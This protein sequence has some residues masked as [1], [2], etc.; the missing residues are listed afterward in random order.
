M[1][2]ILV[3]FDPVSP[4]DPAIECGLALR[5]Q[6][7]FEIVLVHVASNEQERLEVAGT[8][9][10]LD[11]RLKSMGAAA[12]CR[13]VVGEPAET[14]VTQARDIGAAIIVTG[15]HRPSLL[16]NLFSMSTVEKLADESRRPLLVAA[17]EGAK[18]FKRILV[19]LDFS[20]QSRRALETAVRLFPKADISLVHAF[21]VP[22]SAFLP[23]PEMHEYVR[24]QH[25]DRLDEIIGRQGRD[26]L[27]SL[28]G[29][30]RERCAL[31]RGETVPV[32]VAE[33]R[34]TGA[35]L[36]VIGTKGQS[37][38]LRGPVGHIAQ[39]LLLSPPCH[40]LAVQEG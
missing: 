13:V 23:G 28:N 32:I 17:E 29:D 9:A 4:T 10:A 31:R 39:A 11:T 36:L 38:I 26:F 20:D 33:V 18:R 14:I 8:M 7:G 1:G 30:L 34:A 5:E 3:A 22:F 40:V 6:L 2:S 21:D 16:R 12:L 25:L 24:E 19:A 35:D 37:G 27:R 15:P